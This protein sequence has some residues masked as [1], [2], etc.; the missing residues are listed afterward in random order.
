MSG[1]SHFATIKHKKGIADAKRGKEFSKMARLITVTTKKKGGDPD[2]NS[3]LRMAIDSAK[4]INMPKEN[5]ERAIKK[6]TGELVGEKLEELTLEAYGPEKTAIILECITD[7]K[8]RTLGEIKKALGQYNG[9]LANEG[10]VR[11]MF[12]K[13]GVIIV[14]AKNNKEE[15][16]IKAIDA[17]AQDLEWEENTL[18]IYT[19]PE[20]LFDV[21]KNIEAKNIKIE[22]SSLAWVPKE[23]IKVTKIESIEKL[24]HALDD[25]AD[26]QNIYSNIQ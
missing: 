16:E 8:N 21:S 15:L 20:D 13:L 3:G 26:V 24:F 22:S 18:Y 6:G 17:G 2:T 4:K 14:E 7:N 5:I 9:K 10:S 25:S 1:H 19:T 12:T 23:K 11:W